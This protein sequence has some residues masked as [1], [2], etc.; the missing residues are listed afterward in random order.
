VRLRLQNDVEVILRP[1]RRGDKAALARGIRELSPE[2]ARRRFLTPKTSLTATELRYLT[3]VDFVNHFAL[4]AVRAR[5]PYEPVA[6]GRW[7]RSLRSPDTAE[8]AIV[9]SDELQGLGLGTAIGTALAWAARSLGV[10]TFTA[11]ML[12]ENL[13]ARRLLRR[14][15]AHLETRLEHGTY[16][17]AGD[18]AA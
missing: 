9:V 13:P 7:V 1:I 4:V 11:T 6:V 15:S 14:L 12:A 3:E 2:S 8:I 16:E 17:V 18:L 10:R 5:A